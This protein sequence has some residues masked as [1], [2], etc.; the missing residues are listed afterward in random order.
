MPEDRSAA[1]GRD[2]RA[3][4]SEHRRWN[5]ERWTS[6]WPQR[7]VLTSTVT[8]ALMAAAALVAGERVLDVGTGGGGTAIGAARRV[9][10]D[11]E[12]LGVDISEALLALAAERAGAAG[13]GNVAFVLADA[14]EDRLPASG[15]DVAMS[16]FGVMFFDRPVVAFANVRSH[17]RPGGRLA[18]ACWQAVERNPWHTAHPLRP[19]LPPP[20]VPEPGRS[21]PG[22]FSLGDPAEVEAILQGAGFVGVRRTDTEVAVR[23]PA[24]AVYDPGQLEF[25]GVPSAQR[26]AAGAAMV[27]HVRR[28][29]VAGGKYEFPLAYSIWT[30][31]NP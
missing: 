10:P 7:E 28:F 20:P 18:F 19:F 1:E 21:V 3:N 16:Q 26:A 22:A 6:S 13:A 30:A 23:A 25:Y 27:E 12:V 11:G 17:L 5:D 2:E 14:Q 29:E 8:P 24:G 31:S 15:F 9:A 4:E